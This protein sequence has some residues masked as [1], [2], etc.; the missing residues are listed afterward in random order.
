[1]E[2]AKKRLEAAVANVKPEDE[3]DLKEKLYEKWKKLPTGPTGIEWL[4]KFIENIKLMY[5]ML[6]DKEFVISWQTKATIIAALAYFISPID[7][8]PD[9]IPVGG[10]LDD[11]AV[12]VYALHH[13]SGDVARYAE[14]KK[15][16]K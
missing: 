11:A 10:W 2:D 9:W 14:F 15:T 5:E 12:V 4:D 3:K 16:K 13:I 6:F 1:M 7:L 8:V